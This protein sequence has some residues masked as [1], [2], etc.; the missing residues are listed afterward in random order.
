MPEFYPDIYD[1]LENADNSKSVDVRYLDDL[2]LK[3][4]AHT[5]L[6][7]DAAKIVVTRFFQEIRNGMLRG[8]V[9]TLRSFGKFYV[10]SPQ[11]TGSKK[12]ILPKFKPA[13]KLLT[14]INDNRS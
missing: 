13:P 2:I 1:Y 10:L 3:V 5:G 12:K 14:K 6:S 7:E 9:V 8:D 4:R 11:V